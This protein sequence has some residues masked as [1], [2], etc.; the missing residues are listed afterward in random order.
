M[1]KITVKLSTVMWNTI[2]SVLGQR[3]YVEVFEIIEEIKRQ[4]EAELRS[5]T[6]VDPKTM[7]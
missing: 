4:G 6:S 3:P 1:D 2:L 7:R 5:D